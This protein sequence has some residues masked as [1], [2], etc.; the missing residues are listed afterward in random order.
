MGP[1]NLD[2]D[3][4]KPRIAAV[5]NTLSSWRQRILSFQGRALVINALALSRVWYVASLIHMPAWV[6]GEL[7]RLVFSFFW[8]G[9]KDLVARAV[10]VQAPS[11]GGFSGGPILVGGVGQAVCHGAIQLVCLCPSLVPFCF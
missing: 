4:W 9:K 5:E 10:V 7:L 11:V 1:E 8:K 6:L 2:E 3:N